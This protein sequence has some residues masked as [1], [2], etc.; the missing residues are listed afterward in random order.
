[1]CLSISALVLGQ[2]SH[3][4]MT[5]ADIIS[6]SKSGIREETIVLA[7]QRGVANFDTSPQ[8]LV[9]LKKAGVGDKVLDAMLSAP[10]SADSVK[11]TEEKPTVPGGALLQKALNAIGPADKLAAIHSYR[12]QMHLTETSMGTVKTYDRES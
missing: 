9:E 3:P 7:I 5:N 6:M 12:S 10:Q 11:A 4:P 2:D 1:M 8:A